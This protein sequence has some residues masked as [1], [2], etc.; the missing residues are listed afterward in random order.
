VTD[1][2]WGLTTGFV[3]G[4]LWAYYL[5]CRGLKKRQL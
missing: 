2:G 3:L 1:F 4:H 5:L